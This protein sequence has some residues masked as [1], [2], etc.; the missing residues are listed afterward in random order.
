[1][2]EVGE[3]QRFGSDLHRELAHFLVRAFQELIQQTEFVHHLQRGRVNGVSAKIPQ[4]IAVFFEDDDIHSRSCEQIAKH[5]AG[6]TASD[7]TT[8]GLD[9]HFFAI[10]S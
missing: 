10:P 4:K 2:G 3:S 7:D 6:R 5:H 8:L 1:V 9:R